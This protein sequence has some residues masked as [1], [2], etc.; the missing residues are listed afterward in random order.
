LFRRTLFALALV[1]FIV[2]GC[3]DSHWLEIDAGPAED[4]HMSAVW[5]TLAARG[6]FDG[7]TARLASLKLEYHPSGVVRSVFLQAWTDRSE[8]MQLSCVADDP[9]GERPV[10][11]AGELGPPEPAQAAQFAGRYPLA[12]PVLRAIDTVGASTMISL[13]PWAGNLGYYV[14]MSAADH[15][16]GRPPSDTKAYRWDG[17]RFVELP[18]DTDLSEAPPGCEYLVGFSSKLV[19]STSTAGMITS[20]YRG[21][22]L[23]FFFIPASAP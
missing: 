9:S 10:R 7:G 1:A 13:L 19:A 6:E 20:E 16:G 11:I 14:L 5:N 23:V 17:G 3:S 15:L 12:A 4:L 2:S 18:S 8:F 22:A 21:S